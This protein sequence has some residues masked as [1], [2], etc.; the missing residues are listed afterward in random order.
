MVGAQN[1]RENCNFLDQKKAF[2]SQKMNF[3][4]Q[5]KVYFVH[6]DREINNFWS[7][8]MFGDA[9][10]HRRIQ[11]VNVRPCRPFPSRQNTGRENKKQAKTENNDGSFHQIFQENGPL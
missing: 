4:G 11:P 6:L 1:F 5:R 7:F 9:D 8:G 3:V 2:F 10:K